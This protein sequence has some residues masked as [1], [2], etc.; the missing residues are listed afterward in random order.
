LQTKPYAEN[1]IRPVEA[2]TA[3]KR[4]VVASIFLAGKEMAFRKI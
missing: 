1:T 4:D 3:R 2:A